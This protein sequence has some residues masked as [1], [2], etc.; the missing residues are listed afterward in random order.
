MN[1]K[2]CFQCLLLA[3]ALMVGLPALAQTACPQGV[4]AGSAQCG[5]SSGGGVSAS[6]VRGLGSPH[7][8]LTWGAFA[9]DVEAGVTGTSTGKRSRRAARRAAIARCQEMGGSR[10]KPVFDYNHQC[11]VA[12]E[13]IDKT[14]LFSPYL[15]RAATVEEANEYALEKC[16]SFNNGRQCEIVYS[17]CTEPYL[18]Y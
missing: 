4:G 6:G 3:S 2:V 7:W 5:P 10:C 8:V 11:A 15:S 1:V 12:A 9:E 13:P 18:S 17:N 14:E 16:P